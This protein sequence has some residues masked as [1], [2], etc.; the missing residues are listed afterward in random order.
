[1]N[2]QILIKEYADYGFTI[3]EICSELNLDEWFVNSALH[4]DPPM[5][6]EMPAKSTSKIYHPQ[7]AHA[8]DKTIGFYELLHVHG[9]R[10]IN[11]Y[12][13]VYGMSAAAKVLGCD[14][15]TLFA[16]KIH[17]GYHKP[18]PGN[19]L[20]LSL[21]FPEEVRRQVDERDNRMC[22]RCHKMPSDV[23]I[24][25]HK[26]SHPCPVD[27]SNCATLCKRCRSRHVNPFVVKN[28][29]LFKELRF[30]DFGQWVQLCWQ[31]NP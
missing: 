17:F 21:Y 3:P 13:N 2:R 16:L 30:E 7:L 14:P 9:T 19:A 18:L 28:R 1:M 27:V 15:Q 4:E 29:K 24:R 23:E 10:K 20:E 6:T 31:R 5:R 11:R 25:Y 8:T 26:I 12:W 22:V